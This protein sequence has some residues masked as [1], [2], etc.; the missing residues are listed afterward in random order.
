MREFLHHL[1]LPRESNNHRAKALHHSSLFFLIVVLII[2]N[3]FI[4]FV[5]KHNSAILGITAQF[6]NDDLLLQTNARR[7]DK[8]LA[9][10]QLNP[11]LSQAAY[12]KGQDMFAKNYWAHNAPDGTTPWVFIKDSGYEY[13]Y[14]GE[15]LAR[16]YSSA[17]DVVNA[18]M[19]SQGHRDN[20]LSSNYDDVGFAVLAGTLDGDETIL[21]VQEFGRKMA[22]SP[23]TSQRIASN[24]VPT[25]SATP[26]PIR[27]VVQVSPT[28]TILPSPTPIIVVSTPAPV[29][30]PQVAAIQNNPLIDSKSFSKNFSIVLATFFIFVLF[31]DIIVIERKKIARLLSHN[32]DHMMFLIAILLILLL[33]GR[34]III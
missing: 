33:L 28:Q 11:Q 23:E 30:E 7:A 5:E 4:G 26:T 25:T 32:L 2:G 24:A 27:F 1:I 20:I 6:N 17:P 34:G 10:L 9:P 31:L 18:W 19:N 12:Q 21:V 8:G 13:L 3:L 22:G 14:A 16:G 15:N 29:V